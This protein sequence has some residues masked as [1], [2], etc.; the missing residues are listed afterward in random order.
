MI[1]SARRHRRRPA[2][3]VQDDC[4]CLRRPDE[5]SG[6]PSQGDHACGA[7][8]VDAANAVRDLM[9][10]E[11]AP[12][13]DDWK[14]GSF[15]FEILPGLSKLSL[16]TAG[17]PYR[18]AAS[19]PAMSDPPGVSPRAGQEL[20]ELCLVGP[21]RKCSVCPRSVGDAQPRAATARSRTVSQPA[22][23]VEHRGHLP[24]SRTGRACAAA[25]SGPFAPATRFQ[26]LLTAGLSAAVRCLRGGALVE[27][28]TCRVRV[29]HAVRAVGGA[30]AQL[31]TSLGR[32]VSAGDEN[33]DRLVDDAQFREPGDARALRWV[34]RVR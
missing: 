8:A 19:R 1:R 23:G 30:A 17:L 5:L 24:E 16:S 27:A 2:E 21:R 29:W 11:V 20:S 33:A 22:L 10:K 31:G 18:A 25:V 4:L 32:G 7:T 26:G 9:G 6:L 34:G 13:N 15:P 14:P 3:F 12:I 28:S